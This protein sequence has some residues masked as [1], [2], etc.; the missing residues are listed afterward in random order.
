[1][2][3]SK[4]NT[5]NTARTMSLQLVSGQKTLS[6]IIAFALALVTL[7]QAAAANSSEAATF[8]S[9]EE[10]AL[11]AEFDTYFAEEAMDVELEEMIV[12][13]EM[14]ITESVKVYNQHNELI[15]EGNPDSN[16]LLNK[17]VNQADY[18]SE[19]GGEKCFKITE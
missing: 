9:A 10:A 11:V 19:M 8:V 15:G 2:N 3:S 18:L 5:Q 7:F 1:M 4:V 13:E 16:P 14:E 6:A 12:L 17:L